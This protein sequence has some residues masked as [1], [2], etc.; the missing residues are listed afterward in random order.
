MKG[1]KKFFAEFKKFISR[2]NVID[3]AVGVIIGGAFSAIVTS[4]TNKIIMPLINL[5]LSLAGGD[6]LESARTILGQPVYNTPG[7]IESGINWASTIYIDWGAFITAIIDFLLIALVL[8]IILKVMMSA[9]GFWKKSVGEYPTKEERKV[10]KAEGVDM[11]DR[12][13]L[14]AATAELREKNKPI[15]AP[16]KPTQEELLSEILVELKKQN[17]ESEVVVETKKSKKTK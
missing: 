3:M 1:I 2:G 7:V 10:L 16:P 17:T 15:P 4:L 8:F 12:K 11:K 9:Q 6:G 5:L 14:I 13:A